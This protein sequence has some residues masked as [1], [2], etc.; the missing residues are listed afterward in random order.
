MPRVYGVLGDWGQ[1]KRRE[2]LRRREG[3]A[4]N[5]AH[6]LDTV[7]APLETTQDACAPSRRARTGAGYGLSCGV[8][9]IALSDRLAFAKRASVERTDKSPY[10]N[11][12]HS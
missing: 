12:H 9:R 5:E 7:A 2:E 6:G 3:R 10:D 11:R 8:I 1:G 4:P